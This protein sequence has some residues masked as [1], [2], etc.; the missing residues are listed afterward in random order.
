MYCGS[1]NTSCVG[2]YDN[3]TGT[4]ALNDCWPSRHWI[5]DEGSAN[6]YY[7]EMKTDKQMDIQLVDNINW[8]FAGR[9]VSYDVIIR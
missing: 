7:Y 3:G 4:G 6:H 1:R 9:C 2:A 8:A 5:Y